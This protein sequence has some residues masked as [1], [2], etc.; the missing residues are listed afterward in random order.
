MP[1][2]RSAVTA[3]ADDAFGPDAFLSLRL[4]LNGLHIGIGKQAPT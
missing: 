4:V 3:K 1:D 2:I